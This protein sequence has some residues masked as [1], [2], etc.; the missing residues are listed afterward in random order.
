MT[1]PDL[2]VVIPIAHPLGDIKRLEFLLSTWRRGLAGLGRSA[3]LLLV[4][5]KAPSDSDVLGELVQRVWGA[6]PAC[7]VH[8]LRVPAALHDGLPHGGGIPAF[9]HLAG[10][11]G[12][13]RCR[14]NWILLAGPDVFLAEALFRHLAS[15]R[16]EPGCLYLGDRYDLAPPAGG[17]DAL[18]AD[19]EP[20]L[21]AIH[22]GREVLDIKA[23]GI[24]ATSLRVP[25]DAIVDT[26]SQFA[27]LAIAYLAESAFVG[28]TALAYW[29]QPSDLPWGLRTR[30]AWR[31]FSAKWR[32]VG[33]L[34]KDS[35]NVRRERRKAKLFFADY[36]ARLDIDFLLMDR[37]GWMAARGLP[38]WAGA[39]DQVAALFVLT[40][41]ASGR[42]RERY[43]RLPFG[44]C[45]L[46]DAEAGA[47]V[48]AA[49]DG[50]R[51]TFLE[52][53]RLAQAYLDA[54][55]RAPYN[56]EGWGMAGMNFA[57][58]SWG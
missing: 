48:A 23:G 27:F 8:R 54:G 14:G 45:R 50:S 44:I 47:A 31:I 53:A 2:S 20:F 51:L 39:P 1:N 29:R 9:P 30:L 37:E 11:V 43:L 26:W 10:N 12:I 28:R 52:A 17:F 7:P 38:E 3:E 58:R 16:W 55:P 24:D 57:Q 49:P 40:N 35:L 15:L 21:A 19:P 41:L 4:E 46:V 36:P 42:V 13:R 34:F 22:T 5:W 25:S 6:G 32:N 33:L 18:E 56:G